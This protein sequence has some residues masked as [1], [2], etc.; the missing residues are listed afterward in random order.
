MSKYHQDHVL[1]PKAN[2]RKKTR[3][4]IIA[5]FFM[6][7]L[8][9]SLVTIPHK[10]A[11]AVPLCCPII[12]L[13]NPFQCT[14][15]VAIIEDFHA[16]GEPVMTTHATEEFTE[17]REWITDN[18]LPENFIPALM[19]FTQNMSTLAHDHAHAIGK[20]L[21][22]KNQLE[23]Q[24]ELEKMKFDAFRQYQP[25]ETFCWIG[26]NVRSLHSAEA[27]ANYNRIGFQQK[28]SNRQRGTIGTAGA[29]G[30]RDELQSRWE[31]FKGSYCRTSDNALDGTS[32]LNVA[33]GSDGDRPNADLKYT[34]LI[35]LPRTIATD[36]TTAAQDDT[37]KDIIAL[38]NNLYGHQVP[39][40]QIGD[41]GSAKGQDIY[42]KLRS[43]TAKRNVAQSSFS[44]IVGLKS[45][46]EDSS[47]LAFLQELVRTAGGDLSDIGEKPSYYAQLEVLAKRMFQNPHFFANLYE[48]PENIARKSAALSAVELMLERAIAESESRQE[49]IM[50]VLLASNLRGSVQSA[51]RDNATSEEGG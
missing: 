33:C 38:S 28:S 1:P 40:R 36:F 49:M 41:I 32:G 47:A 24:Q 3:Q 9:L 2:K 27:K 11:T 39:S 16:K 8:T 45:E 17:H 50:S 34:D 43:I 35:D 30:V 7:N 48:S 18:F 31:N 19:V 13:C 10:S 29:G 6:I 26:T 21:D 25:S 15:A 5:S 46:G 37:S 44:S 51:E 42:M 20:L 23:T 12:G 14:E 4:I 22:A